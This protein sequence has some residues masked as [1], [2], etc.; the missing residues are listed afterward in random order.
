M[1]SQF[2]RENRFLVLKWEDIRKHLDDKQIRSIELYAQF[3]EVGRLEDGKPLHQYVLVADDWPEYETVWKMIED[4]CNGVPNELDRLRAENA[5][6]KAQVAK[7]GMPRKPYAWFNQCSDGSI[8]GPLLDTDPRIDYTRRAFWTPL[9]LSAAIDWQPIDTAPR[10]NKRPLLLA[11]FDEKGNMTSFD[12]D[13]HWE[14]DQESF[15]IP[16]VY[17]YWATARGNVEEPTHWAFQPPGFDA[18][19]AT[20]A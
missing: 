16:Q 18:L 1:S 9:Y 12:F 5:K 3:I 8:M 4:R 17:W 14:R 20:G 10:N 6:L 13:G 19:E 15:E 7:L 2:K 11:R